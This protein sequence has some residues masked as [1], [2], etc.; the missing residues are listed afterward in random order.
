VRLCPFYEAEKQGQGN[1]CRACAL[2]GVSRAAYYAWS[3]AGPE[4]RRRSDDELL[5]AIKEAHRASR[6]TYGSPRI[7]RALR[8]GGLRVSR[9]RITIADPAAAKTADLLTRNFTPTAHATDTVWCSDISYVRTW[10]GWVYLATVI[11]LA[12]RRVV[13]LAMTDHLQHAIR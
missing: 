11:D 10:E 2:L 4:E 5:V 8:K 3:A 13:G 6:S 1:V 9:K 7:T 12:S